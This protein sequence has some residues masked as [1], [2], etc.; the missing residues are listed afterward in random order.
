MPNEPP[1][2]VARRSESFGLSTWLTLE[3]IFHLDLSPLIFP[4]TMLAGRGRK[5][6]GNVANIF[7]GKLI[8]REKCIPL[9]A[10]LQ[11]NRLEGTNLPS[12]QQHP[13]AAKEQ[14]PLKKSVTATL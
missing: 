5:M 11:E 1:V 3:G 12:R 7:P 4:P 6:R 13:S 2:P 10:T 9:L 8:F 14:L